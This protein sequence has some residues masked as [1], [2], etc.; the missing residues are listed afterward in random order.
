MTKER[1]QLELLKIW[2]QER[3][4]VLFV[5]HDLEEALVLGSRVVVMSRKPNTIQTI[6]DV[7]FDRPRD[8]MLKTSADFQ[9]LRRRLWELLHQHETAPA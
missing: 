2:E 4:T 5:T 8:L 1:L 9:Q 3:K 7:P 6:I